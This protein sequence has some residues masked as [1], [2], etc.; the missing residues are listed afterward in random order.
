M[1]AD[2]HFAKIMNFKNVVIYRVWVKIVL[3]G[4]WPCLEYIKERWVRFYFFF[5]QK[6]ERNC[7]LQSIPLFLQ[8]QILHPQKFLCWPVFCPA[9]CHPLPRG[10][11]S[12]LTQTTECWDAFQEL[13]EVLNSPRTAQKK[14]L[15]GAV[16]TVLTPAAALTCITFR[17]NAGCFLSCVSCLC[18]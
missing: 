5:F 4:M 14:T 6:S 10:W 15:V 2:T 7:Y 3:I 1:P 17:R 11:W 9:V 12:A 8:Q 18:H 13:G 16:S